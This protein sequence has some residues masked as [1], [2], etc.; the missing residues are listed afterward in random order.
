MHTY[1]QP[2]LYAYIYPVTA[3]YTHLSSHWALEKY[4]DG[5]QEVQIVIIIVEGVC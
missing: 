4:V 1:I 3:L 5:S 2:L